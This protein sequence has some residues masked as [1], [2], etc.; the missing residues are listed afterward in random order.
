MKPGLS[1]FFGYSPSEIRVPAGSTV[2]FK[3]TSKD[4]VNGLFIP[5]TS[6]NLMV[7]PGHVTELVH[8]FTQPGE[9]LILCH[10]YCGSGHHFMQ[11]RLVVE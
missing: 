10:E 6:V 8:H 9:Y 1:L 3:V 7:S 11:G 4:V 5:G 2:Y